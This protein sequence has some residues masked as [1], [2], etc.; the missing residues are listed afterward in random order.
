LNKAIIFSLLNTPPLSFEEENTVTMS[1][2]S[3][4]LVGDVVNNSCKG[5]RIVDEEVGL[6]EEDGGSSSNFNKLEFIESLQG[7][8]PKF[9]RF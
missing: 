8:L 9:N 7:F 5:S 3:S 2:F 1:V 4:V 6:F